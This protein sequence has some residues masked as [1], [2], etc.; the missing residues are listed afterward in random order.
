MLLGNG[1]ENF[2]DFGVELRTCTAP[3]FLAHIIHSKGLAIGQV[4]QHGIESI[5]DGDDTRP[6]RNL[7]IAQAT[8]IARAVEELVVGED[9]IGGIAKERDAR[10]DVISDLAMGAHDL[11]FVIIEWPGLAQDRIW[12]RHFAD[13]MQKCRACQNRQIGERHR[14][15]LGYAD[16][17]RRNPLAVALRFRI[18]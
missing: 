12:N 4:T 2:H 3:Y 15:R 14:N 10:E 6:K 5:G 16:R 13:V 9:D 17:K 1:H 18:L 8:W 7:F 11:L